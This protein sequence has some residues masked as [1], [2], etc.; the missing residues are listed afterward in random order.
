M[1]GVFKNIWQKVG[2]LCVKRLKML[3]QTMVDPL[4]D[5]EYKGKSNT[6]KGLCA[7]N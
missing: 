5:T 2:Q 6:A 4:M 3:G 7:L 1:W